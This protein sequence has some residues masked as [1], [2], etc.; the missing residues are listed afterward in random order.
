MSDHDLELRRRELRSSRSAVRSARYGSAASIPRVLGIGF[1]LVISLTFLRAIPSGADERMPGL[2]EQVQ[3]VKSDVLAIATELRQL[4]EKLL[5][6]SDTQVA[7]FV[8]LVGA[9]EIELDSVR[10][11]IDGEPV[12][13]HVYSFKELEALRRGGVQR[14]YT[15]NLP[16]GGHS[17]DV[18]MAGTLSGG[19]PFEETGSFP[20]DKE[21]APRS[22]GLTLAGNAP[23][24][25]RIQLGDW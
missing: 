25:E 2:D 11:E 8:A 21:I 3:E 6:P 10:I 23:R 18:F 12:A 17:I 5:Y 4:E 9:D 20:F 24:G 14:L 16:T 19:T 7:V 1:A 15:G 22:V 13:R